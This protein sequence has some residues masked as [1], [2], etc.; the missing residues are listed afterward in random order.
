MNIREH[1]CELINKREELL[2]AK[3][4]GDKAVFASPENIDWYVQN[5]CPLDAEI[6]KCAQKITGRNF[7]NINEAF[8]DDE[9]VDIYYHNE[10]EP[11]ISVKY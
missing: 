3:S 4:N 5:I 8:N 10:F 9:L 2:Y 6:L 1:F 7:S 11:N